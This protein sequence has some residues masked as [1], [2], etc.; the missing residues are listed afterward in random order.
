MESWAGILSGMF[1]FIVMGLIALLGLE[2]ID[3]RRQ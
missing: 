2:G 3:G 1:A